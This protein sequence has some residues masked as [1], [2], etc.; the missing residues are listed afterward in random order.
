MWPSSPIE[1]FWA[2]A[3]VFLYVS[4]ELTYTI[5]GALLFSQL[6]VDYLLAWWRYHWVNKAARDGAEPQ[7]PPSYPAFIPFIGIIPSIFWNLGAFVNRA[8]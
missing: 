5:T 3:V 4:G 7:L 8:A 2:P 6:L 1:V